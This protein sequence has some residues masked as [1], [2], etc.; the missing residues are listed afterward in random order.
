MNTLKKTVEI[1]TKYIDS[2]DKNKEISTKKTEHWNKIKYLIKTIN[3]GECKPIEA[4]EYEKDLLDLFL[5]KI[6]SNIH[7][8]S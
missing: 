6:V 5:K 1:N 3:G 4:G 8:F 2:T 7:K